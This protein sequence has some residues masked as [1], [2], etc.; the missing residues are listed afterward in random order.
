KLEWMGEETKAQAQ[1]KLSTFKRKIG[2]PDV[3]RG[4]KG[5]TITRKSYADNVLNSRSFQVKRNL[6]D[7]GKPVDRTRW[8]MTPPTVNAYY[9]GVFN[10]IAFPAG[11]LQPPFFNFEADDAIN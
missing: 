7:I 9:S 8:G 3:L 5:L 4:Y 2:S 1:R 10:E 11:I 6:E